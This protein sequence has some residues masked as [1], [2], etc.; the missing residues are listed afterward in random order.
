MYSFAFSVFTKKRVT[1]LKYFYV[2]QKLIKKNLFRFIMLLVALFVAAYYFIYISSVLSALKLYEN[3]FKSMW[4]DHNYYEFTVYRSQYQNNISEF[5]EALK[6][7]NAVK[8]VCIHAEINKQ[9]TYNGK[10]ISFYLIDE[11]L[12]S[13]KKIVK[14]NS[15]FS[16]G[17]FDEKG[18]PQI[19]VCDPDRIFREDNVKL[20]LGESFV[21]FTVVQRVTKPYLF[22][23]LAS[24]GDLNVFERFM[25]NK[26]VAAMKLCPETFEWISKFGMC[27][28]SSFGYV[29]FSEN[30]N[31]TEI[32]EVLEELEE[33]GVYTNK[34]E[35]TAENSK[36]LRD[37]FLTS[38]FQL[39]VI[40]SLIIVIL[41]INYLVVFFKENAVEFSIMRIVSA[42]SVQCKRLSF[43]LA[44][45]PCILVNILA[46]ITFGIVSRL[47]YVP[48]FPVAEK[49]AFDASLFII[50]L[51]AMD[52]LY[53]LFSFICLNAI[54]K[55]TQLLEL[56]RRYFI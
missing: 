2:T 54:Y 4:S 52:V 47:G 37:N 45:F 43:I 19:L 31:Q 23:N 29:E 7:K 51:F 13:D 56:K 41:V 11:A 50:M 24:L 39:A 55:K 21:D 18:T 15:E 14:K 38:Y 33:K 30:A 25:E 3:T 1:V 5:S 46:L 35:W 28:Y 6:A 12:L 26:T 44:C 17:G 9:V 8:N 22:P 53:V 27:S 40:L 49:C 32:D 48:L 36:E 34:V 20:S 16:R 10:E 42:S